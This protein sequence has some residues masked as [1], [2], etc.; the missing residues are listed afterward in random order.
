MPDETRLPVVATII[1]AYRIFF[2][3]L[4]IF[5]RLFWF[6]AMVAFAAAVCARHYLPSIGTAGDES[7]DN[8]G[9]SLEVAALLF[10][11][12]AITAWYRLV[13]LGSSDGNARIQYSV[14]I[15]EWRYLIRTALLIA[16]FLVAIGILF[17]LAWSVP[18]FE[19]A[20]EEPFVEACLLAAVL[21]AGLFAVVPFLFLL[22]AASIGKSMTILDSMSA[23]NGNRCRI[24]ITFIFTLLPGITFIP[25]DYVFFGEIVEYGIVYPVEYLILESAICWFFYTISISVIALAYRKLVPAV[26]AT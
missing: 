8:L 5:A 1:E 25:L 3:N 26:A 10:E 23:T 22:P 9:T 15:E 14:G 20:L 17:S 2:A 7:F 19:E 21:S 16:I 13:I 12:P 6:P 11:I 24:F 4:S 18:Q